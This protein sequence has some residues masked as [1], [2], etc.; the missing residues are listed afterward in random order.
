MKL[1]G[2]SRDPYASWRKEIR[3]AERRQKRSRA[4]GVV[5]LIAWAVAACVLLALIA[6][7]R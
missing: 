1:V 6:E 7:G 2:Q 5:W 3:A 4:R